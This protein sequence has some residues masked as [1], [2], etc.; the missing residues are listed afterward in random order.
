MGRRDRKRRAKRIVPEWM[1][2]REGFIQNIVMDPFGDGRRRR[3]IPLFPSYGHARAYIDDEYWARGARPCRIGSIR[4][5][6]DGTRETLNTVIAAASLADRCEYA[7]VME[8]TTADGGIRWRLFD[9]RPE[10]LGLSADR[11]LA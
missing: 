10:T 9:I 5:E 3:C 8:G 4:A 2:V 7:A 11:D 1:L 6:N